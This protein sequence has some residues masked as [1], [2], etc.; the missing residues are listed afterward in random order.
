MK[1][2]IIGAGAYGQVLGDIVKYNGHEVSFYDP[3]KLPKVTLSAA[4]K[5]AEAIIYAAPSSAS[6]EILPKLPT[7]LPLI[8]AAKGFVSLKPFRDFAEFSA[9]AGAGVADQIAIK[10]PPFGDKFVLTASSELSEFLFSTEYLQV[11]YVDDTLGILICGALKNIYSIALGLTG[12]RDGNYLRKIHAEWR[13]TL[14]LNGATDLTEHFCGL[15]DLLMSV[16]Y[17]SRNTEYGR[18]LAEV[19]VGTKIEPVGT[20]EG[21]NIISSLKD[22][23][24]FKIPE[25]A[26]ILKS[27]IA[28][29]KDATEL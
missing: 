29:V 25:T 15:P 13:E 14:K 4:L 5:S 6:S 19:P 26:E 20:V 8:C 3:F 16:A 2:T 1:I 27:T 28:R 17:G 22:Y 11:E 12:V 18:T 21:V 24:E 9:L 10:N 7:D 23:P